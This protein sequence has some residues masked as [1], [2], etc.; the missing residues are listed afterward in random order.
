MASVNSITISGNIT[1]DAACNE[2]PHGK[3]VSFSVAVDERRRG[4]DG[5]W[6]NRADF[7]D[8]VLFDNSPEGK[9]A[10]YLL[11]VLKKGTY[12]ALGGSMHSR[13]WTD[14]NGVDRVSWEIRVNP[15][16]LDAR[17]HGQGAA[18]DQG[19][20]AGQGAAPQPAGAPAD[21]YPAAPVGPYAEEDF[22]F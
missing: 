12:I 17:R 8:C 20:T 16:M 3:C 1:R 2:T 10:A 4:E 19:A 14:K 9:R 21:L 6:S 11:D 18:A 5:S 13:K 7:F 15:A 22:P